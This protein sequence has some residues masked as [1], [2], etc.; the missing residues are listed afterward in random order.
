MPKA[1]ISGKGWDK[2]LRS[3]RDLTPPEKVDN[4]LATQKYERERRAK[5]KK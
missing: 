2:S 3:N 5:E 1:Y 4:S